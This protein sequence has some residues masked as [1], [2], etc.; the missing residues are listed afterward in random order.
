MQEL[1]IAMTCDCLSFFP[2]FGTEFTISGEGDSE[3]RFLVRQ[4]HAGNPRT[5]TWW[6]PHTVFLFAAGHVKWDPCLVSHSEH[7]EEL[8]LRVSA[9]KTENIPRA[10]HSLLVVCS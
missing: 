1:H 10:F 8:I 2:H 4:L 6:K 9:V 5:F 3:H 7:S